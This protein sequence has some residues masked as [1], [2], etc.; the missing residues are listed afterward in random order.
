MILSGLP[1]LSRSVSPFL[2]DCAVL[3]RN[4]QHVAPSFQS[5]S[6][7]RLNV[8]YRITYDIKRDCQWSL[9][10]NGGVAVRRICD[11]AEHAH[12]PDAKRQDGRTTILCGP[13]T[14]TKQLVALKFLM[15]CERASVEVVLAC[16]YAASAPRTRWIGATIQN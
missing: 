11:P 7:D 14:W 5:V 13:E 2:A 3:S 1:D 10:M 16:T 12:L 8:V 4:L 15:S 9:R 6:P